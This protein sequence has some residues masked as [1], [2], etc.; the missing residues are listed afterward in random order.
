MKLRK[1]IR[2]KPYT[3]S[4][5]IP[6]PQIYTEQEME[7]IIQKSKVIQ[8][9]RTGGTITDYIPTKEERGKW[10]SYYKQLGENYLKS[11]KINYLF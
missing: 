1:Y 8:R 2:I 9:I 7:Q 10:A 5:P 11:K 4:Q 6:E 3:P